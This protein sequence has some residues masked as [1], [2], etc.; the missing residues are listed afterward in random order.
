MGENKNMQIGIISDTHGRLSD[1]A[2]ATLADCDHIIHAGDIGDPAILRSLEALAPTT[3]VLGNND[4]D[5]YGSS[6]RRIARPVIGGVRFLI[7]H[8]PSDVRISWNGSPALS[9]GDPIPHVCVHGHTHV[10]KIVTGKEARP[11]EYVICPG[12]VTAPRGGSFPSVTKVVISG[13]RVA[14]VSVE[15]VE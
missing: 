15:K 10:P 7:G 1:A 8:Y 13:G 2:L 11:A 5:E 4:F 6:V 12:S 14:R 9:P 3:A